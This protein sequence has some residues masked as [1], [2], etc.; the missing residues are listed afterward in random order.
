MNF[1]VTAV[2]KHEAKI[3]FV[4]TYTLNLISWFISILEDSQNL[5]FQ[6]FTLFTCHHLG[7]P[8]NMAN[9]HALNLEKYLLYLSFLLRDLFHCMIFDSIFYCVTIHTLCCQ[10]RPGYPCFNTLRRNPMK[11]NCWDFLRG[12]PS[13]YFLRLVH[14]YIQWKT[15]HSII[16]YK[17]C[18]SFL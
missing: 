14:P 7:G 1:E 15:D 16:R 6:M 5:E 11:F 12:Q 4:E 18:L 17:V 9:A 8:N 3:S 10:K 2:S 13:L